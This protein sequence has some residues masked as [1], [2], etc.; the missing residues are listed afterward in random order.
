LVP[1]PTG[2]GPSHRAHHPDSPFAV[3]LTRMR[4]EELVLRECP[5]P[6]NAMQTNYADSGGTRRHRTG[7]TIAQLPAQR[8]SAAQDGTTRHERPRTSK[9]VR[10]R[11]LP[12][13]FD[14]RPPPRGEIGEEVWSLRTAPRF[15][16]PRYSIDRRLDGRQQTPCSHGLS[17][18]GIGGSHDGSV[19]ATGFR[20]VPACAFGWAVPA[21]G[22]NWSH[23]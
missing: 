19:E 1:F 17:H 8:L 6:A 21:S 15:L 9:P 16:V 7:R 3:H 13:G 2:D 23:P 20:Y 18:S 10:G 4:L 5:R 11:K 14:S 22:S 12:G